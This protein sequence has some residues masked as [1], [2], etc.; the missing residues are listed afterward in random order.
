MATASPGPALPDH[1]D[2]VVVGGGAAGLSAVIQ[3]ARSRRSV[4]LVDARDPRN[5]PAA[6]VHGLLT[7]DGLAPDELQ[8]IGRAEAARYGAVVHDGC[9]V[10]TARVDDRFRV[11]LDDGTV[12]HARRLVVATGIVDELPAIAGLARW[13]GRDVV[14]C[15]YCHGWEVRERRIG[16]LATSAAVVH[17]AT[18]FR[19]LSD[20]VV[21]L[22]HTAPPA[23]HE[24]VRLRARD[25]EVVDGE[26][27][28]VEGSDDALTGVRLADGTSV[29]I[30]ALVV[31]PRFAARADLLSS[32]GLHPEMH[33]SGMG[34]YIP[35]DAVGITDVPGVRVAGNI[36][37]PYAQVVAAAAQGNL[38]GAHLNAELAAEDT[39]RAMA[40][41]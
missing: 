12:W 21:V 22:T 3:L 35:A 15:P 37:D 5:G 28:A 41:A 8:A 40:A 27:V 36:T 19:Q 10:D 16:V 26:V 30:G 17:Q 33:P 11:E 1:V 38:V 32:L 14:H 34:T 25:V 18:L 7:R 23:E 2:V 6:G 13:W 9:V 39:D 20:D 29:S 31:A 24:L 4:L